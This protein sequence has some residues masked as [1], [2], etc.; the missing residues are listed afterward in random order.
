VASVSICRPL[1]ATLARSALRVAKVCA[2]LPVSLIH[3]TG[4]SPALPFNGGEGGVGLAALGRLLD[5]GVDLAEA[6]ARFFLEA[7]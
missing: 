5:R 4:T 6:P 1:A 3:E 2:G 7:T